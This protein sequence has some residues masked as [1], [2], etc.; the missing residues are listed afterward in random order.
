LGPSYGVRSKY[1]DDDQS[2]DEYG[3]VEQSLT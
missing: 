1:C 2:R 3:P